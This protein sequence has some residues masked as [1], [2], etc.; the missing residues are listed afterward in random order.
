MLM[1]PRQALP[2]VRAFD[3]P[4][5]RANKALCLAVLF[6]LLCLAGAARASTL[7][8]EVVA[9]SDGDTITVLDSSKQQH[10]VRLS[11]IDAP[12]KRQAFGNQAR[13]ALAAHVFRRQVS[14]QWSKRDRYGRIVGNVYVGQIDVGLALIKTGL[15]WHYKAYQKEQSAQDRAAYSAAEDAARRARLGLW[16]D[17]SRIAPWEFRRLRR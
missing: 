3:A 15:A 16:Q 5:W 9:I 7:L 4:A 10:K 14:V 2:D 13:Q 8:G 17:A 6:L 12:E 1:S 11:G